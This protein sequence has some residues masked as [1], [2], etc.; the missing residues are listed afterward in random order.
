MK[1][2]IT[3]TDDEENVGLEIY[4]VS[5]I[6]DEYANQK[7]SSTSIRYYCPDEDYYI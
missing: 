4:P 1:R 5:R 3:L 7:G 2:R 6:M